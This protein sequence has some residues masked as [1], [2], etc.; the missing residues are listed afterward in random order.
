MAYYFLGRYDEAIEAGDRALARNP[1]RSI[2]INGASSSCGR[3]CRRWAETRMPRASAPS[4]RVCRRSSMPSGLPRQFGTQEA[5]DHMLEGLKKAGFTE[6]T[7]S[8][9]S[10]KFD[11]GLINIAINATIN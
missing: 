5:R 1:G 11:R 10:A 6:A 3:L 4:S 2:Q 7:G 9:T 8:R